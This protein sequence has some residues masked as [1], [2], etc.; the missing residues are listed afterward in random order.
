[1]D[2]LESLLL[3]EGHHHQGFF[4]VVQALFTIYEALVEFGEDLVEKF[5]LG[6]FHFSVDNVGQDVAILHGR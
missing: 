3:L 4:R 6:C 1:M 5:F 2:K